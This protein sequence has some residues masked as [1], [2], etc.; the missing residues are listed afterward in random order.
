MRLFLTLL[1]TSILFYVELN[2]S[3]NV[4]EVR[5]TATSKANGSNYFVRYCAAL[6][7]SNSILRIFLVPLQI[8]QCPWLLDVA[9]YCY[10]AA[11]YIYSH[12]KRKPALVEQ[13]SNILYPA[14][15][16]TVDR[17]YN[18]LIDNGQAL[19]CP[20]RQCCRDIRSI[21]WV[22]TL[23]HNQRLNDMLTL[24]QTIRKPI[25]NC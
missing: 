1:S 25:Q 20:T 7:N 11:I 5:L 9:I 24:T 3:G 2:T 23:R 14:D 16:A 19:V 12:R 8:G 13:A 10:Y 4:A 21:R 17:T 6:I 18:M 15:S 22:K